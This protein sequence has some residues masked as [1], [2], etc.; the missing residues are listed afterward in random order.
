[1]AADRDTSNGWELPKNGNLDVGNSKDLE[2]VIDFCRVARDAIDTSGNIDASGISG[3]IAVTDNSANA[4]AAGQNGTTNPAFNVDAS[5][6]TSATGIDIASAAAT[7]GVAITATSSGANEDLTIDAKG[8]GTVTV[9][10]TATGNVVLGAAAT[11]SALTLSGNLLTSDNVGAVNTGVT[12]VEH[13]DGYNHTTVLTVSQA[14]AVTVADNAALADGYLLYTLPAGAI[15]VNSAYISMGVTLAED[16]TATPE[17]GLGTLVGSGANATLGD[18]GAGA[19]N[20]LG[21]ATADDCA[22]TAE[23]LTQS[24]AL[25]VEAGD[26]HEVFFNLAA[27][28][29]DTAGADL[30]GDIAGTV[31]INWSFMA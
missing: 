19:E 29:A 23:V 21:P 18:V 15:Y 30:T 22:G 13:G 11:G 28:W 10:G 8:T 24:A 17:V 12:A 4:L 27:T 25:A 20:I 9:N 3:P 26:S 31:V 14:D 16:T 7:A 1:M 6:A 5:T 2:K